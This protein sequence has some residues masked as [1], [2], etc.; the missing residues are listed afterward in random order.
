MA[1]A[2]WGDAVWLG[3][4]RV[5]RCENRDPGSGKRCRLAYWHQSGGWLGG[6]NPIPHRWWRFR[7][8][9]SWTEPGVDY[10]QTAQGVT[11]DF[12]ALSEGSG[13]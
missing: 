6:M 2:V 12:Q 7:S 9:I 13:R 10:G 8:N 3:W 4:M 1:R 11:S 5:H